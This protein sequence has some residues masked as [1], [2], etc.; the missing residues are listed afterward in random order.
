MKI[1]LTQDQQSMLINF[2][3]E[4]CEQHDYTLHLDL[5]DIG[6][7][8][9]VVSDV[10]WVNSE[11]KFRCHDLYSILFNVISKNNSNADKNKETPEQTF[12]RGNIIALPNLASLFSQCN[13]SAHHYS[14]LPLFEYIENDVFESEKANGFAAS[15]VNWLAGL[16]EQYP[17]GFPDE[18]IT[19]SS[20]G[21]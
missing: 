20:L 4:F 11:E 3:S 15:F 9:F 13:L 5:N 14:Y 12:V 1:K 8:V 10:R 6:N 16:E 21:V 7:Y 2:I 19:V 18:E 17:E